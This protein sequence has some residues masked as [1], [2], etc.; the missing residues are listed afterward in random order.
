M[1]FNDIF[2]NTTTKQRQR[3]G[4]PFQQ[5]VTNAPVVRQ[6]P[7]QPAADQQQAPV[8]GKTASGQQ[9]RRSMAGV[10]ANDE[11]ASKMAAMS[12]SGARSSISD[13]EAQQLA[14][15][16][17]EPTTPGTDVATTGKSVAKTG[18]LTKEPDFHAVKHL[19]GFLQNPIRAMGEMVF[20]PLTSTKISD[21]EVVAN[22][23]DMGPNT[24]DEL[25]YI[26]SVVKKQADPASIIEYS[27]DQM[28]ELFGVSYN[29]KAVQFNASDYTYLMVKD[30]MGSYV[31]RWPA[32]DSKPSQFS[33]QARLEQPPTRSTAAPQPRLSSPDEPTQQT[34]TRPASPPGIT[35]SMNKPA[36]RALP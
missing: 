13:A 3:I 1:K 7:S 18:S 6:Q 32:S 30:F 9:T 33:G 22:L 34:P 12:A 19:P 23:Q 15:V 5:D 24:N 11:V 8:T 4:I 31:Y 28:E 2:E 35:G 26:A 10:R 29:A 16:T 17:D 27:A 36:K 14:G 25:N 20:G 21:I